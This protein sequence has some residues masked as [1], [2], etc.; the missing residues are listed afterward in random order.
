MELRNIDDMIICDTSFSC[1]SEGMYFIAFYFIYPIF[2]K[3]SFYLKERRMNLFLR[4][5]LALIYL[6]LIVLEYFYL[7]I[8]KLN[9]LHEI[10]FTHMLT[11]VFICILIDFDGKM[12]KKLFN[13]TKNIF[14]MRKNKLKVLLFGFGLCF[15]GILLFNFIFPNRMLLT[16]IEELSLNESCSQEL[17]ETFGMERIFLNF[18]YVFTFIGAFWGGCFNIEYNPGEWWYQPLII[19]ESEMDKIKK[20]NN[21]KIKDNQ[22]GFVEI[23]FLIL[24]SIIMIAIYFLIWHGFEQ[25]PYI[26]FAFNF[27]MRCLNFFSITFFCFGILPKIFGFLHIKKKVEDIYD[28]LNEPNAE[29]K[30]WSKNF[31]LQQQYLLIIKKKLDILMYI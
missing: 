28:N 30:D 27:L 25:I 22:I 12:H 13:S 10:I 1:L 19:G 23:F 7:L 24:K 21:N 5:F 29:I 4:I 15:I 17:K 14:K 6:A 26:T 18:S 31:Y 20:D 11:F 3:R 8:F 16:M 2:C 9:Y